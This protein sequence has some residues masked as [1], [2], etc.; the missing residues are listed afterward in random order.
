[1]KGYRDP[2][3]LRRGRQLTLYEE[4]VVSGD[5]NDIERAEQLDDGGGIGA[6]A[7]HIAGA[8]NGVEPA[9][10]YDTPACYRGKLRY[11]LRVHWWA[12]NQPHRLA[13]PLVL[14]AARYGGY[15]LLA[16]DT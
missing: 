4:I 16:G 11:H 10:R 6:V 1:M 9:T 7:D 8:Q 14:G 12:N 13:G 2:V 5:G 3:E 15:G